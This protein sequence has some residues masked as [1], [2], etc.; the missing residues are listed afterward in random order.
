MKGVGNHERGTSFPPPQTGEVRAPAEH[1]WRRGRESLGGA[2]AWPFH[3]RGEHR[4][5]CR[6]FFPLC[7]KASFH[8]SWMK[9][10][11]SATAM[12]ID[13]PPSVTRRVKRQ[14]GKD[15]RGFASLSLRPHPCG[16]F[17]VG[18]RPV[19]PLGQCGRRGNPQRFSVLQSPYLSTDAPICLTI[20]GASRNP[21]AIPGRLLKSVCLT[22]AWVLSDRRLNP[23]CTK[24]CFLRTIPLW[25]RG[26]VGLEL[27]YKPSTSVAKV[28]TSSP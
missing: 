17:G 10:L 25:D 19:A 3:S 23:I 14:R 8:H 5:D 21:E 4:V 16:G 11:P 15:H 12:G 18:C 13:F 9:V 24:S 22:S 2:V 1:F 27:Y 6:P 20:F 28:I 26:V 7:A